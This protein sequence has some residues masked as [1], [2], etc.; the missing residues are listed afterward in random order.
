MQSAVSSLET[1]GLVSLS[2]SPSHVLIVIYH[3]EGLTDITLNVS[4]FVYSVRVCV[5]HTYFSLGPR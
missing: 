4:L 5:Q 3:L 1:N 2:V